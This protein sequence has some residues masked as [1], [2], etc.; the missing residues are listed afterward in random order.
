MRASHKLL[1]CIIE[2]GRGAP[3]IEQLRARGVASA[4]LHL[5]RGLGKGSKVRG[6]MALY[7]GREILTVLADA[8][9]AD[10]LFDFLYRAAE[11]AKPH[12]GMLLMEKL[13]RAEPLR[14][15]DL[16]DER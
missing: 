5:A 14:L 1:T 13:Y 2:S 7:V 12:A 10:E 16:P 6:G 15:P 9:Q 3:L 11:I 8:A 4:N